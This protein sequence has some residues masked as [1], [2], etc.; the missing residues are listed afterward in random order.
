MFSIR[1]Q[2]SSEF[3]DSTFSRFEV[4][5]FRP[6]VAEKPL[7]LLRKLQNKEISNGKRRGSP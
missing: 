2:L 7:I 5:R 4:N 3:Q 1:F 6:V